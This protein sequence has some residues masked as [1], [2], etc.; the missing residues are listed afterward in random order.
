MGHVDPALGDGDHEPASAVSQVG[1]DHEGALGLVG[2]LGEEVHPGH[3]E[4]AAALLDLGHDVGRTH[5]DDVESRLPR[6]R[7][8]VLPVAGA[9]DLVAGGPEDLHDSVI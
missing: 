6:D 8:L 9:P 1:H 3:P 4:M 7:R 2:A 5:E